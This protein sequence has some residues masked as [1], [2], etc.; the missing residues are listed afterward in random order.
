MPL[1]AVD[2]CR[3]I[4]PIVPAGQ[5]MRQMLIPKLPTFDIDDIRPVNEGFE[6]QALAFVT[7]SGETLDLA[8]NDLKQL[9]TSL[10][11]NMSLVRVIPATILRLE[12]PLNQCL[13]LQSQCL[14]SLT[15][16]V[17]SGFGSTNY[18]T[19][20]NHD[21][22]SQVTLDQTLVRDFNHASLRG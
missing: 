7:L 8:I 4:G 21:V 10:L 22:V 9:L 19:R 2:V 17:G 16:I 12:F 20:T 18:V 11:H 1:L 6:V 13:L 14:Q 15:F 3:H 5:F